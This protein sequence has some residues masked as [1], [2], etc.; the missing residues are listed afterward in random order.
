MTGDKNASGSVLVRLEYLFHLWDT[1][2][3]GGVWLVKGKKQKLPTENIQWAAM[4]GL[5][6]DIICQWHSTLNISVIM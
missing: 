5:R 6:L 1:R 4:S 3:A 2:G